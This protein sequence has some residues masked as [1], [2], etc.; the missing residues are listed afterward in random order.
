MTLKNTTEYRDA[1]RQELSTSDP[2]LVQ[3]ALYDLDEFLRGERAG[4]GHDLS[5]EQLVVRA[6]ENFGTPEEVAGSYQETEVRVA[7]ALASPALARLGTGILGVVF[8]PHAYGALFLM[9]FGLLTG[10]VY[11]VWAVV[12]IAMSAGLAILIIGI[13]FFI[14]FA[15]SLRVLGLMEGRLLEGLTGVRMPRRPRAVPATQGWGARLRY[16]FTDRR[17]WTTLLYLILALPLGIIGFVVAIVL[18][19][20]SLA[21]VAAPFGQ[22][23]GFPMLTI[24]SF[25]WYAP[26]WFFPFF[27]LVAVVINLMLLHS[28][29]FFARARVGL[30]RAL[31][32]ADAG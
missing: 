12:G 6:I 31:L 23:F 8:D 20:L 14:G 10:L 1:V 11:F 28:A 19:C 30:A 4:A 32:V 3:D 25:E 5:E 29:K 7:K 17:T 13:P 15:G 22:L 26:W 24:G 2:A 21:F 18:L 27:W 16:W 9:L